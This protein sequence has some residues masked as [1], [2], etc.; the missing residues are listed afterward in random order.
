MRLS[1]RV[2]VTLALVAFGLIPAAIVA[3]TAYLA[4][5]QFKR[6]QDLII[7]TAAAA[8]SDKIHTIAL[9]N[10][11]T[12]PAP[13]P[14]PEGGA[15]LPEWNLNDGNRR[16]I[17]NAVSEV[18][19]RFELANAHVMVVDPA[20][21]VLI[22]LRGP[23]GSFDDKSDQLDQRYHKT[24]NRAQNL[25]S[26]D[27]VEAVDGEV[28]LEP[29]VVGFAPIR[30]ATG[31]T[32]AEHGYAVL[33]AVPRKNA[34]ET[35]YDSQSK[36]LLLLATI[37]PLTLIL[38]FLFGR[39]FI[40]PL[41][42]IIDVTGDLHEGHLYNRTGIVRSDEMGELAGLTDS[43]VVKLSEVVGQIRNMT[44]SVSTASNEL[45]SSAQQLAQGAHEQAATLQEIGSSLQSVDGS[46]A[47]NAQHAR[48]TA[49]T[50]N[51][52][53]AQAGRGGEA[54]HQTVAAM[55]E[56]TQKIL[57]VE[58]IAYQTNLLSLNA[59]IEAARAGPHGRGFAVVAGE[60]KKLA[61]R[62]QA[63]AQQISDLAKKSVAVAENA[64]QLLERTVPMIRD[65]SELISEIAAASQE[66]MNAIREINIGVKQLEDVVSQ[67][68]AASHELAAT[69]TDLA[70]QSSSLQHVVEF[71]RL[72]S[73]AYAPPAPPAAGRGLD[74][75][76]SR[77]VAH[78][79]PRRS[80]VHIAAEV[81]HGGNNSGVEG[82]NHGGRHGGTLPAPPPASSQG[83][84]P[85]GSPTGVVPPPRGGVVVN[86]DDDDNF[87]RFS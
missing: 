46:V 66:Q 47:R 22:R 37:I 33:V 56:I 4:D 44:A 73:V 61:E 30:L 23:S 69:S 67:N 65:T 58:D 41:L 59:A 9:A 72:D 3:A 86:L 64:G 32:A 75:Q 60:V 54:V 70:M 85:G 84:G 2:K 45:N 57:I 26:N 82:R 53:S 39:W 62:S 55:R 43:V 29:E 6:K 14:E 10:Q 21:R 34:Y 31:A 40:R 36:I 87:E 20:N 74:H 79:P 35:I 77:G 1:L 28:Y 24:A 12:Q 78:R 11:K 83:S 76:P 71:F 27:H 15:P 81:H 42:K 48:D 7:Q 17:Q 25:I 16:S 80:P 50:A 51:E 68:A 19:T 18:V 8:I 63:A 52:A 5:D 13:A 49:R 38:S